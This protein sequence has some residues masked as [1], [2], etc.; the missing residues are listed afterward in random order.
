MTTVDVAIVGGGP[1]GSSCAWGLRDSGLKTVVIDKAKFPR[2]KVCAG[3]ITPGIVEALQLDMEDYAEGRVLQPFTSFLTG[4]IGGKPL[5]TRYGEV[6]SHGIRRCEFDDYLL[7]RTGCD[8]RLNESLRCLE[9]EGEH[10]L[11]NGEIRARWVIGAGGHFCPVAKLVVP[12]PPEQEEPVVLAQESEFELTDDELAHCP[13][14]GDR[15]E[16][17]FCPDLAGYGWI[18]R[19]GRYLNVGLGREH[20]RHL[21]DHIAAFLTFLRERGRL[22]LEPKESF[23]GHAYRLRRYA[24]LLDPPEGIL[25][26]GDCVGLAAPQ[27]GE[28]I[29][30]AIESGLIA[31]KV[32]RQLPDVPPEAVA[33]AFRAQFIHRF[34]AS[35]ARAS[36][37]SAWVRRL[38]CLAAAGLMRTRWFT[39]RV[40]L[41]QWFLGRQLEPLFAGN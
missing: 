3:W 29:R 30:P 8:L 33:A 37:S 24:P 11:L 19:K 41:D 16:L 14:S 35:R 1:A 26:I 9:R 5:E 32:L 7:R 34:G 15:P 2:H 18:V 4:M 25:L 28:G 38:R 27:S 39:R 20:E 40:L 12:R 22:T 23:R 13:V 36:E 21:G 6:V 10:W 31:A 17:Y